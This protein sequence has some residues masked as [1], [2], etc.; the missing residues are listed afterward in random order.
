MNP[1]IRNILAVVIGI[2]VCMGVNGGI[3]AMS[4]SVIP[5]P[6]GVDVNDM[7]SIR[8]ELRICSRRSIL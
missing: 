8:R 1:V 5:P 7:E 4:A 6:S 2:V 3:I